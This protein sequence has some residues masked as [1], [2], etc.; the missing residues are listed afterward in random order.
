MM[1]F[2]TVVSQLHSLII[3]L[4]KKIVKKKKKSN[5]EVLI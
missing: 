3:F 2:V 4:W 5:F 1:V